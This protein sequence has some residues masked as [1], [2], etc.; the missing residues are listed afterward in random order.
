MSNL[1]IGPWL[2]FLEQFSWLV[3]LWNAHG[4][5]RTECKIISFTRRQWEETFQRKN[6]IILGNTRCRLINQFIDLISHRE[7][8]VQIEIDFTLW[9][10]LISFFRCP[11]FL[12]FFCLLDSQ[13]EYAKNHFTYIHVIKFVFISDCEQIDH[14]F[15]EWTLIFGNC[16]PSLFPRTITHTLL[17]QNSKYICVFPLADNDS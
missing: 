5:N 2:V 7:I 3:S 9:S 16:F 11:S 13:I 6:V 17:I 14:T 1:Q 15:Y 8:V 10:W 4:M 12:I